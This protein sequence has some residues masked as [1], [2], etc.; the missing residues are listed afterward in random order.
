MQTFI[1]S[2]IRSGISLLSGIINCLPNVKI[3]SLDFELCLDQMKIEDTSESIQLINITPGCYFK[4]GLRILD[5]LYFLK[6]ENARFIWLIRH[7]LISMTSATITNQINVELALS[8]W[9][10]VNTCFWYLYHSLPK[11]RMIRIKYED[12]LL[13]YTSL[14]EVFTF[15]GEKYNEQYVRYGDFDQPLIGNPIFDSGRINLERIDHH[16]EKH[17]LRNWD[18][19]SN[20]KLIKELGYK[21]SFD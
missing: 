14:K 11:E 8:Y 19:Y 16:P 12:I 20:T 17:L 1:L 3:A 4:Y 18:K 15:L 6:K 2:S 7:P 5:G 10:N 21:R 13:N 9:G